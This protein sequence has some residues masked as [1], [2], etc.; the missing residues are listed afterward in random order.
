M[1]HRSYPLQ[2]GE[3]FSLPMTAATD[4]VENCFGLQLRESADTLIGQAN[5]V[6]VLLWPAVSRL[7]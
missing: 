3:T 1:D 2:I 6:H 7:K 5:A 4:H